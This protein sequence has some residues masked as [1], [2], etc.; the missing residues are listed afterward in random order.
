MLTKRVD[1]LTG[2]DLRALVDNGAQEGKTLEYKRDLPGGSDEQ[3]REFL[4]DV[5][6]FANAGGGYIVFGIEEDGG[7]AKSVVGVKIEDLDRERLRLE[8]ILRSG[9]EPR[10]P[11]VEIRAV[12]CGERL[13]L[14]IHVAKSWSAPHRVT[15]REHSKFYSRTSAGKYPLDVQELRLA[16][17]GSEVVAERIRRFREDRLAQIVARD[18]PVPLAAGACAVLHVVPLQGFASGV[19]LDLQELGEARTV[20]PPGYR[21]FRDHINL[22][23]LVHCSGDVGDGYAQ[24]FRSGAIE[25]VST[26]VFRGTPFLANITKGFS[27]RRCQVGWSSIGSAMWRRPPTS[28]SRCL[29]CGIIGVA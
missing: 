13:C 22:D 18:T 19:M 21:G 5:S 7:Q 1:D 12:P 9:L 23:G 4:A 29:G 26:E 16:F 17:T 11:A 27:S 28:F 25:F 8:G 10:L 2:D 3:K 6:S 15:F 24:I 14:V 20:C